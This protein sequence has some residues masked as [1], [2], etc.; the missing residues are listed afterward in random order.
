MT[1][2]PEHYCKAH[3][4][5]LTLIGQSDLVYTLKSYQSTDERGLWSP[6]NNAEFPP[7]AGPHLPTT[8]HLN[9][10]IAPSPYK[11]QGEVQFNGTPTG[12]NF[13]L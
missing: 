8:R 13:N 1:D 10:P 5:E 4:S 7:L 3:I 11:E 6:T 2:F 12:I 9:L